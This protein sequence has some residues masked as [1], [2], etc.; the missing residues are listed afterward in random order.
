M[1]YYSKLL[2]CSVLVRPD[3]LFSCP[4][5]DFCSPCRGEARKSSTLQIY[6]N[7]FWKTSMLFMQ[8]TVF[9]KIVFLQKYG[10]NSGCAIEPR[11]PLFYKTVLC[12]F[13]EMQLRRYLHHPLFSNI[14][15]G[16]SRFDHALACISINHQPD[17][18]FKIH[19]VVGRA[20]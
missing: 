6:L 17:S 16:K 3:P 1:I 20:N 18:I 4:E 11:R 5:T 13:R 9:Q 7:L 8:Q 2:T 19:P 10:Q 14:T 12:G 15:T